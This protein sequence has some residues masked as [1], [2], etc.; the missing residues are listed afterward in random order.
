MFTHYLNAVCS[1][2][3]SSASGIAAIAA[4]LSCI[5]FVSHARV[6][7]LRCEEF[8][9]IVV[10]LRTLCAHFTMH[11][12]WQPFL[13]YRTKPHV[14]RS[15]IAKVK[16][17]RT[18]PQCIEWCEGFGFE[19]TSRTPICMVRRELVYRVCMGSLLVVVKTGCRA[20]AES[21]GITQMK[22]CNYRRLTVLSVGGYGFDHR[23]QISYFSRVSMRT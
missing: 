20:N 8:S 14:G 13:P 6:P 15:W 9:H 1:A 17:S 21:F 10:T 18:R 12:T 23:S 4:W 19:V 11:F 3:A 2:A 22:T 16:K 5:A 7:S